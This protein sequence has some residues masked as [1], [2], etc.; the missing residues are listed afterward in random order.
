MVVIGLT[1]GIGSGKSTVAELLAAHGAHIVDADRIAREVVEAGTPA[2]AQLVERFGSG[3]LQ[4]DGSLDRAALAAAAFGDDEARKDLN[5]ITHP[6]I[7]AEMLA[8]IAA[9]Q[10]ADPDGVVI[11]DI[12][13]L[14]EGGPN[15]YPLQGVI[16]VDTAV[17]IAVSR[18]VQHRGFDEADALA[19]VRAQAT[20]EQRRAIADIVIDNSGP[21]DALQP[22]VDAAWAWIR[23]KL[24]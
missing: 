2:L 23:E 4:T 13:L 8:R 10:E 24:L 3:I 7:G 11:L 9:A 21:P 22:Q 5:A 14:A 17:D 20:R 12:P 6:A 15:R 18:L 16:V 1:G 19:R